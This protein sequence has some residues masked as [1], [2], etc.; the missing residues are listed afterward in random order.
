MQEMVELVEIPISLKQ[1]FMVI[2]ERQKFSAF[3]SILT[4]MGL[5]KGIVFVATADM[6]NFLEKMLNSLSY[7][8]EENPKS[9]LNGT[10]LL[11]VDQKVFKL[12]G[13][14]VQDER[15]RIFN[16]FNEAKHAWLIS[17]DVGCRGLDFKDTEMII[18]FDVPQDMTDYINRI[19]RTARISQSGSSLLFLNYSE[20]LFAE[21]II[22]T[23]HIYKY[24]P[25]NCFNLFFDAVKSEEPNWENSHQYLDLL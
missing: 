9:K 17:T 12:H 7:I 24:N 18:L 11:P 4:Q 2:S 8:F 20:E 13:H 21:K 6:A 22:D 16:D 25:V 10:K 15:A 1:N 5:T 3:I 14:I 19:G 23:F